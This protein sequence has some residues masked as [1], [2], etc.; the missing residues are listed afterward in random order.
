MTERSDRSM[1]EQLQRGVLDGVVKNMRPD[2]AGAEYE[3]AVARNRQLHPSY[4]GSFG[5]GSDAVPP[6]LEELL[7][8]VSL[9]RALRERGVPGY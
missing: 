7:P 2:S 5:Q 3:S 1:N 9:R 8:D 6:A 4:Y